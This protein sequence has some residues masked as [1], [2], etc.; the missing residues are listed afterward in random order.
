MNRNFSQAAPNS[1]AD[2]FGSVCLPRAPLAHHG[3]HCWTAG[4]GTNREGGQTTF[5]LNSVG[6]NLFSHEYCMRKS[7][8][9]NIIEKSEICA[10]KPDDNNDGH[11]DGGKDACQGD[12]GGPLVCNDN[13]QPVLY[14]VVSWG[15]GCA[16]RGAPGVYANVNAAIPWIDQTVN[17]N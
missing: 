11:T 13:G 17:S 10:G 8:Y 5:L 6:I 2:C 1:C 14:G 3:R 9:T 15:E 7:T 16:R 4:W 12:S